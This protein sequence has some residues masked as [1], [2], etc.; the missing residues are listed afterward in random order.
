MKVKRQIILHRVKLFPKGKK[1][2]TKSICHC[3]ISQ[4]LR[5]KLQTA[6]INVSFATDFNKPKMSSSGFY[7]TQKPDVRMGTALWS[8]LQH[9]ST[10]QSEDKHTITQ[11]LVPFTSVLRFILVFFFPHHHLSV[12]AGKHLSHSCQQ[13]SF[14]QHY[15]ESAG[16]KLQL[17]FQTIPTEECGSHNTGNV[18]WP[19]YCH[20]NHSTKAWLLHTVILFDLNSAIDPG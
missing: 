7:H 1:K 3:F 4:L 12:G 2:C 17:K 11:S 14:S 5:M 18:A 8:T 20:Q 6:E 9:N 15:G 13:Y 16:I 19:E 10:H